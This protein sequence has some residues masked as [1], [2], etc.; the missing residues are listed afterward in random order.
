[1]H[2]YPILIFAA[3]LIFVYGLFSHLSERSPISAAMVFVS[4]GIIGGP[5]GFD[6]LELGMTSATVRVFAHLI[7]LCKLE[8]GLL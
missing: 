5:L 4:V 1:V 7:F 2:E 6:F 3:L 8:Y